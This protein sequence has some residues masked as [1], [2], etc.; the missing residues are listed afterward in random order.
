MLTPTLELLVE[1]F[2]RRGMA[3]EYQVAMLLRSPYVRLFDLE[4]IFSVTAAHGNDLSQAALEFDE[5]GRW[6]VQCAGEWIL[7][8]FYT[9][10]IGISEGV[11]L[12]ELGAYRH[13]VRL[14]DGVVLRSF[15]AQSNVGPLREGCTT[16]RMADGGERIIR[17]VVD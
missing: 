11:A 7:P 15:D 13:F 16:E 1:E 12:M 5:R 10:A 9:S 6:G 2:A 4:H 8:P 3:R 17:V 14:S